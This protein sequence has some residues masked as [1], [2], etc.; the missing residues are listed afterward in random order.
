MRCARSSPATSSIT[1]P[2]LTPA[3]GLPISASRTPVRYAMIRRSERFR[4]ALEARQSTGLAGKRFRQDLERNVAIELGI[5]GA[6]DRADSAFTEKADHCI[7][8]RRAGR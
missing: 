8:P 2:R 4:F 3:P 1:M 5:A 6:I 7:R